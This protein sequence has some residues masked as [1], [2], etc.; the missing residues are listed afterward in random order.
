MSVGYSFVLERLFHLQMRRNISRVPV[1]ADI[2]SLPPHTH[3][4]LV[5]RPSWMSWTASLVK[6]QENR[7]RLRGCT[8]MANLMNRAE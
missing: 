8:L 2:P 4:W 5:T 3:S 6:W 1:I 7:S